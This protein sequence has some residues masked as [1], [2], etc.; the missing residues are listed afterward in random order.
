MDSTP[1][2]APT[3]KAGEHETAWIQDS[4]GGFVADQWI[5]DVPYRVKG[6]KEATVY[7]CEAH[8][9]TGRA[10]IAAKIYRPRMFRAM[11][12]D[13]MYRQGR[14]MLDLA[15]KA[16]RDRRRHVAIRKKTRF[17]KR[18]IAESWIQN[19][20]HTLCRLHE[21]GADVP[22]PLACANNAILMEYLGEAAQPAP[23]LHDV[24]L[25]P[26]EAGPIF[27]RLMHNVELMLACDRIHADLSAYNVLYWDGG[28]RII[29]FP[30]AVDPA[31]NPSAFVL[32]AR[33]VERL[34]QHF[35]R[36]AVQADA[37][38]LATELWTRFLR[39]E[40]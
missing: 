12:N 28:F 11:R 31:I 16:I 40:L 13:W 8:P 5:T 39:A 27:E 9:S 7:C 25:P 32:L 14:E 34:C 20:Y 17:G 37:G 4:L 29:D 21:A 1:T 6:G 24:R 10:L 19:E 3:L 38:R 35:A 18:I 26:E 33:D 22:T 36:H 15:G 2:F 30:Q 23:T